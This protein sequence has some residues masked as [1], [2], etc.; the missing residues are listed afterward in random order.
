MLL[1]SCNW[2]LNDDRQAGFSVGYDDHRLQHE[3]GWASNLRDIPIAP[4]NNGI[5][6]RGWRPDRYADANYRRS[7]ASLA[8]ATANCRER[9]WRGGHDQPRPCRACGVR[10]IYD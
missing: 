10:R 7:N 6:V 8:R 5:A 2:R 3:R 4:H 9:E 1:A